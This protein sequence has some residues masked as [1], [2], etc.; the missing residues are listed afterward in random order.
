[1]QSGYGSK[2]NMGRSFIINGAVVFDRIRIE[3][4]RKVDKM[5][6]DFIDVEKYEDCGVLGCND[7]R[8]ERNAKIEEVGY[9]RSAGISHASEI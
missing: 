6:A 9:V 2:L 8:I 3:K 4:G 5:F 7:I 1:L